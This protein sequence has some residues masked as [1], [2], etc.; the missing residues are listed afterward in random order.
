QKKV[1]TLLVHRTKPA[2]A[3]GSVPKIALHSVARNK[4]ALRF[5]LLPDV[6]DFPT[7]CLRTDLLVGLKQYSVRPLHYGQFLHGPFAEAGTLAG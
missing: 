6:G 7:V 3:Y 4:L 2:R 1:T 5:G